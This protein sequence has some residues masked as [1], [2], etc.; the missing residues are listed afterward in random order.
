MVKI[1]TSNIKLV[2]IET[3]R[4]IYAG[5][6]KGFIA[7]FVPVFFL[8]GIGATSIFLYNQFGP[9]AETA[10]IGQA[11]GMQNNQMTNNA[12]VPSTGKTTFSFNALDKH[13]KTS[14]LVYLAGTGTAFGEF[15]GKTSFTLTN[16]STPTTSDFVVN[17][18]VA[19][20]MEASNYYPVYSTGISSMNALKSVQFDLPKASTPELRVKD[21]EANAFVGTWNSTTSNLEV[22]SIGLTAGGASKSYVLYARVDTSNSQFGDSGILI[23]DDSSPVKYEVGTTMSKL[24]SSA[25]SNSMINSNKKNVYRSPRDVVS[26]SDGLVE[27]GTITL[28]LLPGQTG[29]DVK[30]TFYD[31]TRYLSVDGSTI[32]LGV[33]KDDSGATDIG[34]TNPTITF[35]S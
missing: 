28:K 29:A 13:D 30:Y 7:L 16:I 20:L 8:L 33:E 3:N 19:V 12:V 1:D 24:G 15:S 25:L 2:S 34:A 5:K 14:G 10:S 32:N 4:G 6:R 23:A 35:K 27:I 22:P 21:I 31:Q 11:P 26:N 17:E 18:R 9:K